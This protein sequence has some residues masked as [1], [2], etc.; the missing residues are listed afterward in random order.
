MA[1]IIAGG[2]A[3]APQLGVEALL[4]G[5]ATGDAGFGVVVEEDGRVPLLL[6]PVAQRAGG[7]IVSAAMA[8]ENEAHGR[9]ACLHRTL[10][11][12]SF[13]TRER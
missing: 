8:D 9:P 6:Q 13:P 10:L 7:S 11:L 4:P 12:A 2:R 3:A 5:F 1:G